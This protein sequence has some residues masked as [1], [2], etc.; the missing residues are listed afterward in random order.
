MSIQLD[1][2]YRNARLLIEEAIEP[3]ADGRLRDLDL[4]IGLGTLF[5]M[6][7]TCATLVR[8]VAEPL[9]IAQMQSASAY[10]FALA[11][12]TDDEHKTTSA[13]GCLWDA[14]AGQYWEAAR[15]IAAASRRT[16]NP[17]REHEDDF[18]YV[19]FLMH[20]YLRGA[21]APA[22]SP[23]DQV[24][25][26]TLARW[27][28]VLDGELDPRLDLCHA[29]RDHE[30]DRFEDAII[31]MAEARHA[32]LQRRFDKGKLTSEGFVWVEPIWPEGLALLRLA[33]AEGLVVDDVQVPRVP[34]LLRTDNPYRYDP[35]AWQFLDFSPQTR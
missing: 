14:M 3:F 2:A 17:N 15:Q 16:H 25:L 6:H 13:A 29:L 34:P 35:A 27:E 23:A 10:A 7:G 31:S 22:P 8:G 30:L 26:D 9:F 4:A 20:R 32:D 28:A 1:S 19:F 11:L 24:E 18:C 5:R 12:T 21:G 33:A